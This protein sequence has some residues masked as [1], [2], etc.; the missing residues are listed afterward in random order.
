M[1]WFAFEGVPMMR[2]AGTPPERTNRLISK[3]HCSANCLEGQ[4]SVDLVPALPA[5]VSGLP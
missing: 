5:H 4:I 1:P 2:R 3:S